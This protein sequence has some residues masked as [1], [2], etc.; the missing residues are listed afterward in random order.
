M[1]HN[2]VRIQRRLLIVHNE[3]AL[4]GA[5]LQ[6]IEL[7]KTLKSYPVAV[8]CLVSQEEMRRR[9]DGS[10]D[11]TVARMGMPGG[12]ARGLGMISLL[13]PKQWKW[14]RDCLRTEHPDASL[15]LSLKEACIL[16]RLGST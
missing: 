2:D 1:S 7:I 13:N 6:L 16:S 14:W 8:R 10:V 5:E 11:V 9:L 15:T 12:R 3:R 4:G